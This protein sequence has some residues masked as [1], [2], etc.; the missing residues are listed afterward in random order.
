MKDI[1]HLDYSD[2]IGIREEQKSVERTR[3]GKR[4]ISAKTRWRKG[5]V[6]L[7]LTSMDPGGLYK[8]GWSTFIQYKSF[9]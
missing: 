8:H 9:L 4:S 7:L 1:I 3:T 6:K 2:G 5:F